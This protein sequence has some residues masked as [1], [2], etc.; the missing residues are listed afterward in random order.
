MKN[1]L[2]AARLPQTLAEATDAL[3]LC[4]ADGILRPVGGPPLVE[5]P[6][7][8]V[9]EP[10]P[11][12]WPEVTVEIA[13]LT[14]FSTRTP[15]ITLAGDYTHWADRSMLPTRRVSAP[16]WL[17]PGAMPARAPQLQGCS[18]TRRLSGILSTTPPG[19]FSTAPR[20]AL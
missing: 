13:D 6:E 4:D 19:G 18:V 20:R 15:A 16:P 9:D 3:N 8:S 11:G 10:A 12:E 7:D 2:I 5:M 17:R 1:T 14:T